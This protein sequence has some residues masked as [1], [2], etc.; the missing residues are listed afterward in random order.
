MQNNAPGNPYYSYYKEAR[1]LAVVWTGC[2]LGGHFGGAFANYDFHDG[3]F[4]FLVVPPPGYGD[5]TTIT[6]TLTPTTISLASG[7][8]GGQAG[9]NL[10]L[11][12]KWFVG[13]EADAAWTRITG[14]KSGT[15]SGTL[16]GTAT[17]TAG[18]TISEAGTL[19]LRTDLIATATARFGYELGYYNQ[20]LVYGKAGVAWIINKFDFGGTLTASSCNDITVSPPTGCVQSTTNLFDFG[21]GRQNWFGWT[22]GAGIEWALVGGWSVKGEY[23]YMNF[24]RHAQTLTD[25]VFGPSILNIKQ[26]ISE[27]KLGLNYLFGRPPVN[28]PTMW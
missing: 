23:D 21:S 18:T 13:V 26:E 15:A 17:S 27:V 8:I 11:G 6:I 16:T 5:E 2:Y 20:G 14:H 28:L 7:V 10:E 3:P 24:G 25:P 1:P 22:I 4:P 9:C 12:S 19:S